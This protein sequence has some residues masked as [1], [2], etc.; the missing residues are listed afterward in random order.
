MTTPSAFAPSE[1]LVSLD[2]FRGATI[3]AMILVNQPGNFRHVY[4][5]LQHAEWNG[6]RPPDLI[7]PFFLFIV[8]V[9]ITLSLGRR[10]RTAASRGPLV[11]AV[12]RRTL[13]LLALGALLN[14]L[15]YF[16]WGVFRIPGVLQRIAVCYGAAALAALFL[17]VRGQ[18]AAA[19]GLLVVY[20][21]G[22]LLGGDLEPTSNFAAR[23][24]RALM[25]HHLAFRGWDPEGLW[26]TL[27][28]IAS[29]IAGVLAGRWMQSVGSMSR[30]VGGL[31]I[32]G[33]TGVVVGLVLASWIP[34]NKSLWSSSYAV[35]T[36]GIALLAFCAVYWLVDVRGHR[37]RWTLPFIVY[38]TNAIVAYFG[39]SLLAKIVLL[40]HVHLAD[41]TRVSVKRF[42]VEHAL[43]PLAGPRAASL[44]YA[45]AFVGL[46]LGVTAVL[47]RR[48]IFLKV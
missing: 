40:V 38:G 18:I 24:D 19:A 43:L 41:G 25:D 34:V 27:P 9:A 47:Y 36:T 31:L 39:S 37:G 6:C 1:R 7:F 11:A 46:W 15:P 48:R 8:G 29:T 21:V 23:L 30:R 44:L 45:L 14:A 10:T 20:Q 16:D 12:L 42:T 32:A 17:G 3:A 5:I 33:G 2:V 28:A 4:P 35:L 13:L 26:S 22:M